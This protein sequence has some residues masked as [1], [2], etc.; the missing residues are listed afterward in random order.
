[1]DASPKTRAALER[2]HEDQCRNQILNVAIAD[3]KSRAGITRAACYIP[4]IF[5]SGARKLC[6]QPEGEDDSDERAVAEV[7]HGAR[8]AFDRFEPSDHE[9]GDPEEP[10]PEHEPLPTP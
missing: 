4:A 9:R 1:M 10:D 8:H 6:E 3:P 5:R 2:R 7:G